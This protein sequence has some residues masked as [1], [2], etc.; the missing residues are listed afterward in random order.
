MSIKIPQS[1]WSQINT[2]DKFGNLWATKN[3]NLDEEGYIKLSPRSLSLFNNGS[4]VDNLS[5]TD[6]NIPVA[7]GRSSE[8]TFMIATTD[9]PFNFVLNDDTR[10]VG[11]DESS[12]NP[13]LTFNS[14]GKWW[15]NRFYESTATTVSYKSG[16]TWTAD[17]ITSLTSG[18]RHYLEVFKNRNQLC[19]SNGNVVKQYNTSHSNTVDLTLPSD[20]EVIGMAYNNNRL[21]LITRLG[22]DSTGQNT[23]SYFFIWDGATT[24][25]SIGVSIGTYSAAGIVPYKSSFVILTSTGELLYWNGGGFDK[26][27]SFPFYSENKHWGDLL[28]HL[29]YGDNMV[30]D[31]DRIYINVG[32]DLDKTGDKREEYLVNNPSGVW[33]YDPKAGLSHR[34]SPSIS[35]VYLHTIS[36]ANVDTSTDLFTTSSPVPSTGNPLILNS[37]TV[38][39]LKFG[40]I[41]FV[42]KVSSTT[43]RL[44]ETR[45][46]ALAGVY[47]DITSA[48]TNQYFWMA[49]I[50]DFGASVSDTVGAVAIYGVSKA[51][52]RDVLFGGRYFNSNLDDEVHLCSISPFFENRGYLISPKVF[53]KEVTDTNQKLFVKFRA[54]DTNDKIIIKSKTKD[55]FNLPSSTPSGVPDGTTALNLIWTSDNEGYTTADLSEAKTYFNN[56]GH[57]ELELTAGMGAG[58]MAQ[59]IELN[60]DGGT[61]SFVLDETVVGASSGLKSY[62]V[63]NNWE[64]LATID[65]SKNDEGYAEILLDSK[66]KFIQLK[67]ELRGY[68]TTIEELQIINETYKKSV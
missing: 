18:V 34:F 33:C 21:G 4:T 48:D 8:G 68:E 54:L 13:N 62:F 2:S 52:Y 25:A 22:T 50:L 65:S 57:L 63:V 35:P 46:K 31:G 30:V 39:G 27:I 6:F 11:E 17:V 47:I 9:E 20:F 10:S 41:Y 29:T 59:V 3:I 44:A 58:Q 66:S 23:D 49:N 53:S 38:G 45:E 42:I 51:L 15:Q 19:V 14:H 24:Q 32:F 28:N 40:V 5:N 36:Q 64:T 1:T 26:L 43:F 12:D 55:V 16:S 61:Y 67:V 56:G 7:F 37:G 60:E